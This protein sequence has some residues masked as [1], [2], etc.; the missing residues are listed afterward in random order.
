MKL[1]KKQID[2]IRA[3][4]PE[5]LKGTQ[6]HIATRLGSYQ[7]SNANWCYHAGWTKDGVL[8]VIRFGEVM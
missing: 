1:T 5:A 3:N 2:L 8:L 7:P 4:T 6:Q